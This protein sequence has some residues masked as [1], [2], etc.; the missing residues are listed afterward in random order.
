[1]TVRLPTGG[2]VIDR[3][4]PITFSFNGKKL[5]GYKGDTVASALLA[6]NQQLVGRSF[7]YHR[8]RGIFASG[9]EEPNGL[10]TLGKGGK[11]E[12]NQVG[13]TTELTDGLEI[14]S[15]NHWPSLETDFGSVA[16]VASRLLPAGFYYKTFMAP[17]QAWKHLFE[18]AIRQSAGLGKPP[19]DND[20]DHYEHF[21]TH[22][23]LLVVGGGIAGLLAARMLAPTGLKI[24]LLEQTPYFGGRLIQ[25]HD[26][27]GGSSSGEWLTTTLEELST[28]KNVTLRNR[29][30]VAGVY[31]H[32]FVIADEKLPDPS[33]NSGYLK[34][35]LWKIRTK[36][37]VLATGAIERP[38]CFVGNDIPG[39]RLASGIRDFLQNYGVS[40]GDRTAVLTN[41]D[42]AYKTAIALTEIGLSVPLIMDTRM[43]IRGT[44]P[45][46]ARKMG[47][48]VE[49]ARGI[50]E[51]LG[52]K[53]V[54]GLEMCSQVG[55]G[56]S[57]EIIGCEAIAVSGGW[58]PTVHLWSHCNGKLK[59]DDSR[60]M[61]VPDW[62]KP[63]VDSQGKQNIFPIGSADGYLQLHDIPVQVETTVK[64]LAQEFEKPLTNL[65]LPEAERIT[66]EK[67]HGTWLVPFGMKPANRAKAWVDFQN[68]VKV[69]DIDLALLEGFESIEHSK[70]YTT[71]GMATDQGKTSNV[72]GIALVSHNLGVPMNK[73]GTTT[74]R[75]PYSPIPLGTIAGTAKQELF[76]PTRK[77]PIDAW[78]EANNAHWE[79][80]SDWRRPYCYLLEGETVENA[81]NREALRVRTTVGMLD[82]TTLGKI[83]VK[84]RDA[85]KF[86][87]MMYTNNMGTLKPG[88]CRYGLM[89]DENGFLMDDGVV[90]RLDETTFLCHTTTGGAD[91]IHGWMEDWLQCEWWD[92]RVFT[93]NITDQY[94][95]IGIA[96]PQAR[97]V[98]EK[99]GE[100]GLSEEE[101]PFMSW[102][103]G[104]LAG[105]EV[106]VYRISFS[107]E[108]SYEISIKASEGLELWKRI[109]EAGK[110]FSIEPY[111]TEAL[112][113]LRAEKGF[114]MIGDETDGTVI[115]QD[116]GLDWAISKKK[117]DFLG[118]RGQYRSFL[119]DP[120]RWRLVGLDVLDRE[121]PLPHGVY[122]QSEDQCD[123]G[124][125]RM[126]GR[127][128]STYY[129][130]MLKR[131]IAM[132]LVE[133]GPERMGEVLK[134]NSGGK[135]IKAKI[136]N[137]M[138]YDPDKEVQ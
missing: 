54:T 34:R 49:P 106:Q 64:F 30:S 57:L 108:L 131:P 93:A 12:P 123:F 40:P 41:N 133:R 16:N 90:A 33:N 119:T 31:D 11:L 5:R 9:P 36:R 91:H 22:V 112:H 113:V 4:K 25:D 14:Q 126:E 104:R 44:L 85:A 50:G 136:V 99:L 13:S 116:L 114:I 60:T 98:L 15:Q 121:E 67:C 18:P 65:E 59:W 74:F 110:E 134:F 105:F 66:E 122:A 127:V 138:F 6:N 111:G 23:D 56:T 35:R 51:V 48:R 72:N 124:H 10:F 115:P 7:K 83:L 26:E 61:F 62:Q 78:H 76:K 118:K 20:S 100:M 47:I 69:S 79:P 8:P 2:T 80:V 19:M 27:F 129:S 92:W 73:V 77:T 24:L 88:R 46:K 63:P 109:Y 29:T 45:T 53:T 86:L 81:V 135:M 97:E 128:T 82:A 43:E 1:M 117:D 125:P 37:I 75:P 58:S 71:L 120:D 3:S 103:K 137:H 42:D 68:D 94:V 70:R 17:K 89:C 52:K 55:E 95:Q 107:G 84:G 102:K 39:V 101:L 21:Y 96:G 32:G 132:G 28:H 130:P 38:L 87:D